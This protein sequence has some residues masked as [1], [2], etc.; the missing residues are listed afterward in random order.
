MALNKE[1]IKEKVKKWVL[2]LLN[3]RLLLCLFIAWMITNGWSYLVT[4]IGVYFEITWLTALGAA[5]AGLLWL[6]FTPEKIVTVIIAIFLL[7][8][9][10]PGDRKTLAVLREELRA[11]KAAFRNFCAKQKNQKDKNT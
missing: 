8:T 6:P 3:P 4:A 10:F 1:K 5:Y 9:I 7:K 2:F 11:A